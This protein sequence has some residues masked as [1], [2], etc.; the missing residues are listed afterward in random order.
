[1]VGIVSSSSLGNSSSNSLDNSS[2][3]KTG[4]GINPAAIVLPVIFGV[5][6]LGLTGW[7][8]LMKRWDPGFSLRTLVT[9]GK[10][11]KNKVPAV[12]SS[13]V[14]MR[15]VGAGTGTGVGAGAVSGLY[16]KPKDGRNVFRDEMRRQDKENQG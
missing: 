3:S 6:L 1:M 2:G 11:K 4:N 9:V 5:M 8:L 10:G 15:D 7:Y 12:A 13:W 14:G 16:A